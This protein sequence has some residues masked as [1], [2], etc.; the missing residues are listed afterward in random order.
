MFVAKILAA[1]N[2]MRM[3]K[4]YFPCRSLMCGCVCF[5]DGKACPKGAVQAAEAATKSESSETVKS[6]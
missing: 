1:D 4:Q 6:Y 5:C 2:I 3:S